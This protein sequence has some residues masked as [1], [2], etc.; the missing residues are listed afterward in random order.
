MWVF[1]FHT[2]PK[3]WEILNPFTR[4]FYEKHINNDYFNDILHRKPQKVQPY[5]SKVS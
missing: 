4:A 5:L 1:T 3:I 2:I